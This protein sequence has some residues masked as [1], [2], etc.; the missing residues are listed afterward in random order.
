[1]KQG[2]YEI[3]ISPYVSGIGNFPVKYFYRIS[4]G[5]IEVKQADNKFSNWEVIKAIPTGARIIT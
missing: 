1:M 3:Q 4:D 2:M 5:I